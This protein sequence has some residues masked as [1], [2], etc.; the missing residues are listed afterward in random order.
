MKMSQFFIVAETVLP[1]GEQKWV[2][3]IILPGPLFGEVSLRSKFRF[4]I[5]ISLLANYKMNNL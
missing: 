1:R 2:R 5:M 4:F 3:D